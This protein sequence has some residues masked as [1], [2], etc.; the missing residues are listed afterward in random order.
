MFDQLLAEILASLIKGPP[1]TKQIVY[2]AR[3]LLCK[4]NSTNQI[5]WLIFAQ[6]TFI[7]SKKKIPSAVMT[8][9]KFFIFELLLNHFDFLLMIYIF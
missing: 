8:I 3:R 9:Y 7:W 1:T 5:A 2:P 4:N 6:A